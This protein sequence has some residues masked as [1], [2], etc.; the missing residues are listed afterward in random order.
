MRVY[1]CVSNTDSTVN[2]SPFVING[3]AFFLNSPSDYLRLSLSAQRVIKP[4]CVV[5][6]VED[7][8]LKMQLEPDTTDEPA[9]ESAADV[10]V[11][12]TEDPAAPSDRWDVTRLLLIHCN[13]MLDS[14]LLYKSVHF[15][16]KQD[17]IFGKIFL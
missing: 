9:A 4:A 16:Q 14:G 1:V 12:V 3:E 7:E 10:T 5:E 6:L 13:S 17:T 8:E 11:V 2:A 15:F